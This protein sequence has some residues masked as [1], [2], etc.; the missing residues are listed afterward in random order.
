MIYT[1]EKAVYTDE[2]RPV[3]TAAPATQTQKTEPPETSPAAQTDPAQD[4]TVSATMPRPRYFD[5]PMGLEIVQDYSRTEPVFNATMGDWRTHN[6]IDFAG[7]IGDPIKA[8][9]AGFVTA[10]YED[11][12]YGV[13][14]E[15][16]HGGGITARYCGIG[17]GSNVPVGTE[18]KMDDT[19]AYLG[20]VPCEAS[21]GAHLHFEM[22]ENGSYVDPLTILDQ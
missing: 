7:V 4:A 15:I 1:T 21:A 14:L 10:V 3:E 2:S 6:G 17:K 19:I 5:M 18:V 12:M 22:T 8:S 9:A 11:P 20:A 16:D 13:V